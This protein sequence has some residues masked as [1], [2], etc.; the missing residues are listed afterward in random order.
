MRNPWRFTFDKL[1]GQL[2]D[3]DVGNFSWE[4]INRVVKGGNYG[5]PLHEGA[6]ESSCDGFVNPT[7]TYPHDNQS[8]SVTA[9]PVYRGIMFPD[10]Y[11]GR[12]FFGDY[13][14]GVIETANLNV[15]GD[16]TT[17]EPFDDQA[18]S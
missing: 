15:N 5:W 17:V 1:T 13:A 4:E 10:V 16:V 9:G 8:A 6:C 2:Y 11:K 18:G 3:G 12:L 14:K 7:Y